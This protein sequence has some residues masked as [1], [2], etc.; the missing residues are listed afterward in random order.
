MNSIDHGHRSV[1]WL[2]M[3]T[4]NVY[5]APYVAGEVAQALNTIMVVAS[6]FK[7]VQHAWRAL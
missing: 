4:L 3:L 7:A 5:M 2:I 1:L 6:A